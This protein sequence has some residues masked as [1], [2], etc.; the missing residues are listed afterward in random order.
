[1]QLKSLRG[2]Q[3]EDV[4][5]AADALIAE[6][7][8]PTIERVRQK[9]GRGSPNTVSPMLETW[10]AT[11][12]SRL[13]V[14]LQSNDAGQLPKVLQQAMGDLWDLA[15]SK[16]K[17]Q[18]DQQIAKV[19]FDLTEANQALQLKESEFVQHQQ[20]LAAKH[21]ALEESLHVAVNKAEDLMS[22]LNQ[23]QAL[24]SKREIEIEMLRGR[25]A[26][27]ENERDAD[28]RRTNEEAEKHTRERQNYEGR[29]EAT[30][31][32]LLED[33]DKA[34]QDTKKAQIETKMADVRSEAAC[35]TWQ[36]KNRSCETD[37]A[38]AQELLAAQKA[39]LNG[40]EAALAVSNSRS[41][42]L[43]T[44]L[45]IHQIGSDATIA[46]LTE[47]LATSMSRQLTTTKLMPRK[48]KLPIRKR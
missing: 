21:E 14:N 29:A 31:H 48:V 10:F 25:L 19:R 12:A 43:R 26:A 30:R 18:A 16:G 9:I 46:R 22:R 8:R 39:K 32:K 27:V 3:Q 5:G 17:E 44:L 1:M 11:L 4:W 34:R 20:V 24:T 6:G 35:A 45:E 23:L 15:L 13:G 28:R 40:L 33:I 42:E 37:L 7:L 2:V 47:A 36:Q 38:K 41:E